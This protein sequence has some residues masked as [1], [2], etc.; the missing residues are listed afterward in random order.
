MEF[1]MYW[2]QICGIM[3]ALL[4]IT[5]LAGASAALILLVRARLYERLAG[6][7]GANYRKTG[8][9]AL[10]AVC[11]WIMVIGQ[12]AAAAEAGSTQESASSTE[13]GSTQESAASSEEGS[14]H[15]S[16][17]SSEE[18]STREQAASEEPADSKE[19]ADSEEPDKPEDS[20]NPAGPDNPEDQEE[21]ADEQAPTVRIE[22][23]RDANRG[24]DG[25]LY[26]REDNAGI[27]V[28]LEETGSTDTG[29]KAYSIVVTD[30]EGREIKRQW[31][32]GEAEENKRCVQEEISAEETAQ[33]SDGEILVR[34]EAIDG[35]DSAAETSQRFVLDTCSPVLTE[36]MTYRENA[37]TGGN[38]D[39]APQPAEG[40]TLYEERD[41]YYRDDALTTRI[42]ISDQ[43]PV[44]WTISYLMF[45]DLGESADAGCKERQVTGEGAEGSVTISE[46]GIYGGF[47]ICGEDAAGNK[48]CAAQ[49]CRC[50]V[51][52]E[53][54]YENYYE[55]NYEKE[56]EICITRRKILDRTPPEAEIRFSCGA[57]G[58]AYEEKGAQTV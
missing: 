12:S 21:P 16:A 51:D 43:S 54:Y 48:M 23:D 45:G 36:M 1:W 35:A 40:G 44:S 30:S 7:A 57:D 32:A 25:T 14:T 27:C 24:S 26:C 10:I 34:A 4:L 6:K 42:A 49:D 19:P 46:E 28:I 20:S 3:A 56:R 31:R 29:I 38:L 55:N 11:V 39:D 15:E 18:G 37:G 58:Y 33:L 53:D 5:A 41:L 17:A 2:K 52:T 13:T 8:I 47:R 22:M 9:L 50:T